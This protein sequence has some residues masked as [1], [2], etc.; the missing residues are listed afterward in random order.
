MDERY[1][2]QLVLTQ[3]D[4]IEAPP[5]SAHPHGCTDGRI[6][7]IHQ[8]RL[9]PTRAHH[10]REI[11]MHRICEKVVQF[12][13]LYLHIFFTGIDPVGSGDT[14]RFAG[15]GLEALGEGEVSPFGEV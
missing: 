1:V 5:G 13:H 8:R 7:I 3:H 6:R 4:S 2:V 14:H 15:Q 12:I 9:Q 10:F 11:T